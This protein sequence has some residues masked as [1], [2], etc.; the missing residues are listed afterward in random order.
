MDVREEVLALYESKK[1]QLKEVYSTLSEEEILKE[2]T[3]RIRL[4]K[5]AAAVGQGLLWEFEN[6][7]PIGAD[8][9]LFVRFKYDVSQTP[10]DEQVYGRWQIGDLRQLRYGEEIKTDIWEEDRKDPIRTFREIEVQAPVVAEDGYL[11]VGFINVPLNPTVVL[12]PLEDGLEVLYKADTF[13]ANFIRAAL[14]ILCRLVFLAALG[15]LA[16]SF[17]SFPV[18]ILFCLVIFFTGTVSGFLLDSFDL[19]S[20]GIGQVYNYTIRLIVQL[21]PRFDKYNPTNYLVPARLLSWSFLGRVALSMVFVKALL[22]LLLALLVFSFRELA[23]I[24]V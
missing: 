4:E 1:D 24:I 10:P 17:L 5:R 19:M 13:T 6:V 8:Q 20:R 7:K 14:L 18:A 3:I 12:F 21:L 22:L 23:K 11:A 16:G 9:S 15:M 2:L